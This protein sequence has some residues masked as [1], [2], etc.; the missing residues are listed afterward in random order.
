MVRCE[1]AL[2]IDLSINREFFG[3]SGNISRTQVR[4]MK[5]VSNEY[6]SNDFLTTLQKAFVD[7]GIKDVHLAV[8]DKRDSDDDPVKIEVVYP[9]V[10]NY[11]AYVQPRV[12][13]EVGSRSMMEP[14][15]ERSFRSMI[16][17]NHPN[18][19]F[20]DNDVVMLCINPE[21]TVLEK[22]FL[23]HEEHQRPI[24]KMKVEGRSRHFY[25]I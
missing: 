18:Q 22:L 6:I 24:E 17:E 19:P 16:G 11:S 9:A 14:A 2:D 20:A 3:F 8:V 12:L 10:T 5:F 7:A 4:K 21:R 1:A 25:D 23:L 13:L 15:T